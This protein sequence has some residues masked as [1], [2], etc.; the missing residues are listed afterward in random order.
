M[1]P[2]TAPVTLAA[3]VTQGNNNPLLS[4]PNSKETEVLVNVGLPMATCENAQVAR[5]ENN[6]MNVF[7]IFFKILNLIEVN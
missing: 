6:M 2:S 4:E 7:F 3:E 1:V 5:I